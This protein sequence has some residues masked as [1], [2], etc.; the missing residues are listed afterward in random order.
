[1]QT[2][3]PE[4]RPSGVSINVLNLGFSYGDRTILDGASFTVDNTKSSCLVGKNG[5]GKSTLL[6]I[7]ARELRASGGK[8][9]ASNPRYT[10][11]YVPQIIP[12]VDAAV[13]ALDYLLEAGGAREKLA[14]LEFFHKHMS[15]KALWN[16][17][18]EFLSRHD[19][20]EI[21]ASVQ[22]ARLGLSSFVGLAP[23]EK[24]KPLHK[25]SGGQKTRLF[26]LRALTSQP[27]LL[28]LDEPDNNLDREG[29]EWLL[30]RVREYPNTVLIVGHRIEFVDQ[31]AERILELSGRDH[32]IYTYTGSYSSY[33]DARAREKEL[34]ERERLQVEKERRHDQPWSRRISHTVAAEMRCRPADCAPHE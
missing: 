24:N 18:E 4:G 8:V 27:D 11:E 1:M 23:S 21:Y 16:Q 30:G 6:R 25:L 19:E 22:R 29:K 28:L 33:L 14:K 7:L 32:K 20:A 13:G 5:V 31:I 3:Q 2:H 34:G 15:E 9:I 26:I 12:A 17:F 10:V